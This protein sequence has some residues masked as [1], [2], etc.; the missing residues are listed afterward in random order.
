MTTKNICRGEQNYVS[1]DFEVIDLQLE[2]SVCFATS[3]DIEDGKED[4][5]G[6]I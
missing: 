6:T 3:G 4:P 1:P 2:G 5:W